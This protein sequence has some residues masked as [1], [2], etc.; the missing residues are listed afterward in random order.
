[1][2]DTR[3]G[4][5]VHRY[6]RPPGMRRAVALDVPAAVTTKRSR[7]SMERAAAEVGCANCPAI[8]DGAAQSS[9]PRDAQRDRAVTAIVTTTSRK[10]LKLLRAEERSAQRDDDSAAAAEM[11]TWLE[12]A[13]W[14]HGPS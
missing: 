4:S 1:M 8:H 13:K 10:R 6:K 9:T 2:T 5:Y 14:G 3:I 7:R 11:R 12:P